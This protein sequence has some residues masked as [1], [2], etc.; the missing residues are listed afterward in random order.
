MTTAA[1]ELII[2]GSGRSGT[3]IVLEA[4]AASIPGVAAIPRLAGRAPRL[5]GV[6]AMM[7][8]HGLGPEA[9]RRPSSESTEIFAE[10]GLTQAL[11]SSL[12][13]RAVTPDDVDPR[14]LTNLSKRV[15][16]VRKHSGRPTVA[17]KNTASCGRLPV[18]DAVFPQAGYVHVRRSPRGVVASMLNTDFWSDMTLW[19]DGRNTGVYGREEGLSPER[20]A[21]RHWTKQ[22]QVVTADL[23]R[24]VPQRYV[25]IDYVDFVADPLGQL[26]Q[27]QKFGFGGADER[28]LAALKI[29]TDSSVRPVS[30]E[31]VEAVDVECAELAE[32]LGVRL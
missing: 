14:L 9:W 28:A 22:V 2:V 23:E 24:V 1:P 17:I 20:V 30:R 31:I 16:T 3:T 18:L 32:Q 13:G 15:N 19:W 7:V 29:S 25:N 6:A 12:G 10:A 26:A 27:L 11:Q 4:V 5:S 21:A 8:R